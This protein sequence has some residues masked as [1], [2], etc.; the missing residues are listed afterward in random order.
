MNYQ[1]KIIFLIIIAIFSGTFPNSV[2]AEAVVIQDNMSG[3]DSQFL[4]LMNQY[5]IPDMYEV[6]G[7]IDGSISYDIPDMLNL[8]VEYANIRLMKNLKETESYNVSG[9]LA[10]LRIA[11]NKTIM[12][13]IND[14]SRLPFLNRSAPGFADQVSQVTSRFSLYGS[15]FEYQVMQK[16]QSGNRSYPSLAYVP[17]NEFNSIMSNLT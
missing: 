6:K 15:W 8:S 5:W 16:Y 4:F 13:E 9:D 2:L 11:Y 7:R 1:H 14:L 10:D 3:N 17:T 12:S